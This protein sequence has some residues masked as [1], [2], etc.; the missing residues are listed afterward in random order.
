MSWLRPFRDLL[1]GPPRQPPPP[2]DTS[3]PFG[4]VDEREL[5][6]RYS[7]SKA[8]R[9]VITLDRRGLYRVHQQFW[10][11]GDW[12]VVRQAYWAGNDRMVTI[13]DTIEGARR[14]AAEAL[15]SRAEIPDEDVE[16]A[17]SG[18]LRSSNPSSD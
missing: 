15:G 14:L 3:V 10:D 16:Q 13:T 4:G 6:V 11:T 12:D 18:L 17:V 5:E 8:Y 2:P 7:P 1:F 9:V